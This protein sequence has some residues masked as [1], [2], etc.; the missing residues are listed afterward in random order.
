MMRRD[1]V[2]SYPS[3]VPP[4]R[5]SSG[6]ATHLGEA[7]RARVLRDFTWERVAERFIQALDRLFT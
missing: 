1:R 6:G 5:L 4:R 2:L 7:G 3:R